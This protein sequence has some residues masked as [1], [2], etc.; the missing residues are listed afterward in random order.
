MG[1]VPYMAPEQLEGKDAD[2]RTDLFAFGAVLYE[3]VTGRPAFP[4]QTGAS[5]I[6]AVMTSDPPPI[7]S[8][9]PVTP[10]ALD[11]LVRRCL[12]KDPDVRCDSAHDVADELRWIRET[13]GDG[14]APGAAAGAGARRGWT[15]RIALAIGVTLA[16]VVGA[17]LMWWLGPSSSSALTR[18]AVPVA[19]AEQLYTGGGTPSLVETPGGSRTAFAWTPDGRALVF[20]GE[21]NGK[22]QLYVRSLDAPAARPVPG[23]DGAGA[24]AVSP[25]GQSVAFW[26]DGQIKKASLAG[27]S[28]VT[29]ASGP[30]FT[31][32]PWG[33][34]WDDNGRLYFGQM[35]PGVIGRI[36]PGETIGPNDKPRLVTRL[37]PERSPTL[38]P[39]RCQADGCFFTRDGDD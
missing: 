13:G 20:V 37:A 31:S 15:R 3:M 28:V 34:A 11:R 35:T 10:P 1:T 6:S 27:G 32:A 7:A 29:M 39:V 9:L 18:P 25:D 4:G 14:G 26:A 19:D 8:L 21:R 22:R 17:G 16:A 5:V 38:I 2:G 24:L 36:D 23:T 33:L 12:A 30:D